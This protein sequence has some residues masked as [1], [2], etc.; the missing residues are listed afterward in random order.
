MSSSID[1]IFSTCIK[2]LI[3]SKE[4]LFF[5]LKD[6]PL[7]LCTQSNGQS[8]A[9]VILFPVEQLKYCNSDLGKDNIMLS[10]PSHVLDLIYINTIQLVKLLLIE[11]LQSQEND[12]QR[13]K[14][15]NHS[16]VENNTIY[17]PLSTIR[18]SKLCIDFFYHYRGLCKLG[19]QFLKGSS[20][21]EECLHY[22]QEVGGSIPPCPNDI[23]ILV[24]NN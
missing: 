10:L 8:R 16:N 22:K 23:I 9:K 3:N 12:I 1:E 17:H 15:R 11:T 19:S 7:T 6:L 4:Y 18:Y 13:T 20:S 2:L 5:S 24:K 21:M 14:E